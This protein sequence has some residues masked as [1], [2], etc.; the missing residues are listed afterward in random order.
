MTPLVADISV[1]E[2]GLMV[3]VL[4]VMVFVARILFDIFTGR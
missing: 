2:A 4:F 3:L 1:G